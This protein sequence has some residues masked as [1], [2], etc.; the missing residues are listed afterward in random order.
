MLCTAMR[1]AAAEGSTLASRCTLVHMHKHTDRW[2][3][4]GGQGGREGEER[5][6][7]ELFGALTWERLPSCLGTVGT[8]VAASTS[9]AICRAN[10][11]SENVW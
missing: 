9:A 2:M 4:V 1:Y 3:A 10:Q 7:V 11:R 5:E 6:G 8:S